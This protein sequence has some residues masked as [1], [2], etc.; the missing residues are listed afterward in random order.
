MD[1]VPNGNIVGRPTLPRGIES[2]AGVDLSPGASDRLDLYG[3]DII[4]P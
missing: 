3:L 4:F 1:A 2:A